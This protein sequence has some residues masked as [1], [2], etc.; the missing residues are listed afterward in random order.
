M[1]NRFTRCLYDRS[2]VIC[3]EL[4]A[5]FFGMKKRLA[6]Y[7]KHFGAYLDFFQEA[8]S[9]SRADLNAFQDEKIKSLTRYC[10]EHVPF[11]HQRMTDHKL[12]PDDIAKV[13]DLPKMPVLEKAD[14]RAAGKTILSDAI[15]KRLIRSATTS[16]STG[17]PLTNYWTLKAE[18]REYAFTWARR[19]PGVQRGDSYGSFTGVQVVKA[20]CSHPPYWRH[21]YAA[22][23]TCYSVFHITPQSIPLYVHEIVRREHVYL[24][25]YPSVL[26]MLGRY[27][28][29]QELPRP[30]SIKA[31]FVTSEELLPEYRQWI[32]EG[33][34]THVYNMYGQN[35]KVS[36]I[37]EYPCGHLHYDMDYGVIE[38]LPMGHSDHDTAIHD[39][40]CTGFDNLAA[41]LIR[42]RVGDMLAIPSTDMRCSEIS[43]PIVDSVCGRTSQTL[44]TPSGR[45]IS[46]LWGIARN[47]RNIDGLQC[48]QEEHGLVVIRVIKGHGFT[49]HDEVR[50]LAQ[51]HQKMGHMDFRIVYVDELERTA[52]GKLLS[53]ISRVSS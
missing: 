14:L 15:P 40:I 17:Y 53:I 4:F 1:E 10:Y 25:G 49:K 21:N 47:C 41:P 42:Y 44:I 46:S 43:S 52:S 20:N 29:E 45:R 51:F 6:R 31:V 26:A 28:V 19:R 16:G 33:F 11:Y 34:N 13:A 36:S 27:I 2:P 18:Q 32:E 48:V 39:M 7:G 3:Q 9:W 12:V 22:N 35:E 30:Q 23:Q 38:F 24:T 37:T 5:S 50:I 8:R